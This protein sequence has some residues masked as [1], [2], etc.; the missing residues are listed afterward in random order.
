MA[1]VIYK[2]LAMM[3]MFKKQ[4]RLLDKGIYDYLRKENYKDKFNKAI[5]KY[6]KP[7]SEIE[8]INK[9]LKSR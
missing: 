7:N 6:E 2:N 3:I 5:V 1:N 4:K 9:T 8:T